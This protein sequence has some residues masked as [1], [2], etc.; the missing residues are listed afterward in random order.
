MRIAHGNS[1]TLIKQRKLSQGEYWQ[2]LRIR[3]VECFFLEARKNLTGS[4]CTGSYRV[5][6]KCDGM[7]ASVAEKIRGRFAW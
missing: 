1:I 6:E 2:G 4:G 3:S 7:G 5:R